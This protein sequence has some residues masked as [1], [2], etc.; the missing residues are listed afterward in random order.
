M[1]AP[2]FYQAELVEIK[3]V[4]KHVYPIHYNVITLEERMGKDALCH[5]CGGNRW[6]LLPVECVAVSEGGKSY[7]ECLDCGFRTH[8]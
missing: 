6:W 7:C 2:K 8:L 3:D 1:K 4:I 5:E